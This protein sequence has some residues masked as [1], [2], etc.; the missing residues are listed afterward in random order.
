VSPVDTRVERVNVW[1]MFMAR[2][3]DRPGSRDIPAPSGWLASIARGDLR[4]TPYYGVERA[5]G[6][7][8][9]IRGRLSEPLPNYSKT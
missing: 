9:R 7:S 3:L 4:A 6:E 8:W 5:G 2:G 1:T